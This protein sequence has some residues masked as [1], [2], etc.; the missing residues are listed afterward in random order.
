MTDAEK[1]VKALRERVVVE[2]Q[3]G[4]EWVQPDGAALALADF[5]EAANK[6]R[7]FEPEDAVS[8]AYDDALA[9]LAEVL[10]G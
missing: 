5:V 6:C 4:D 10:N 8:V 9:R 2:L 7:T 1:V 3:R